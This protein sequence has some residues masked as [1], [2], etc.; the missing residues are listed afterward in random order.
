MFL[1]DILLPLQDERGEPFPAD[2]YDRLAQRLT[3]R[4]GRVHELSALTGRRPLEKPRR[5]GAR[6][7]RGHRGHGRR[8]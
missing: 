4:F 8:D 7:D 6:R 3:E 5:N 1:I 2:S